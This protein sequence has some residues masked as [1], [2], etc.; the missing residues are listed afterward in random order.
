MGRFWRSFLPYQLWRF[1]VI[2]SKMFAIARRSSAQML[3]G[4]RPAKGKQAS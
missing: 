2:N 1:F 3:P 4:K